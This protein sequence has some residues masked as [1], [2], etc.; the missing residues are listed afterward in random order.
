[1]NVLS[2]HASVGRWLSVVVLALSIAV[3]VRAED[4]GAAFE[5][6]NK[7]FEQG[8][9]AGA[10]DAYEKLRALRPQS[11]TL[12]FNAGNAWYRAGQ[13]GRA[14]ADW[15]AAEG[16]SPRDPG[17]RYNLDFVRKKLSGGEVVRGSFLEGR[18]R[19]LTLNEWA[20]LAA[21]SWWIF[22]GI[23]TATEIWPARKTALRH[24]AYWSGLATVVFS[25]AMG[26]AISSRHSNE[27]VVVVAEAIVRHGPLDESQVA[28]QLRDGTEVQVLDE[29]QGWFQVQDAMQRIGWVKKDQIL[30]LRS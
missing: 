12:C 10:A 17:A 27:G 8:K 29:K 14:M 30:Q 19:A 6:A 16:L 2:C 3:V 15:R 5:S 1:M 26:L 24:W 21:V 20:V 7:L 18:L 23:L 11:A 28:F 22:F 25:L 4:L 9:Y 13:V